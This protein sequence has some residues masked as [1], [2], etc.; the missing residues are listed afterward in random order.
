MGRQLELF[1]SPDIPTQKASS[2]PLGFIDINNRKYIGSKYRLLPFLEHH[3]IREVGKIDSFFDGFSGTGVVANHFKRYSSRV[4]SNDFLYSNY[5][6][7]MVFLKTTKKNVSIDRLKQLLREL[8]SLDP[9]EGY[10]YQN[11][12]GTYFTYDNAGKIDSIREQIEQLYISKECTKQ[13][14]FVLLTSLIFAIDKVANTV[15]QYDAYLKHLGKD[16]YDES[17]KH[18]IDSNVYKPI[19]LPLPRLEYDGLHEVYCENINKLVQC[20][21][22]FASIYDNT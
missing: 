8:N 15:G 10:A 22:S 3:I 7:N 11:F 21:I 20:I 6:I 9:I 13:E 17:G 19:R 12:G 4:I 16:P 1:K 14:K 18:F 5:V 2:V